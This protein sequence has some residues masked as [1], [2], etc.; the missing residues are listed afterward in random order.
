MR[1]KEQQK[2]KTREQDKIHKYR[3]KESKGEEKSEAMKKY[4]Q[5]RTQRKIKIVEYL[6]GLSFN[7]YTKFK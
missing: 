2:K 1:F 7:K 3:K 6:T 5:I 4:E